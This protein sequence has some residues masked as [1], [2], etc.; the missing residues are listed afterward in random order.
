MAKPHFL[1]DRP[2]RFNPSGYNALP[3]AVLRPGIDNRLGAEAPA[4]LPHPINAQRGPP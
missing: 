1:Q 3:A 2:G 4:A